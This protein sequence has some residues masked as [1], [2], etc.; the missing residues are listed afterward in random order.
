[1]QSHFDVKHAEAVVDQNGWFWSHST[2]TYLYMLAKVQML[3]IVRCSQVGLLS[4]NVF[5]QLFVMKFWFR[6][7]KTTRIRNCAVRLISP[8]PAKLPAVSDMMVL[9]TVLLTLISCISITWFMQVTSMTSMDVFLWQWMTN[10]FYIWAILYLELSP[11]IHKYVFFCV[12]SPFIH[13]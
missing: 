9:L 6:N 1:M 3:H 4:Y 7:L 12:F 13:T 11:H 10:G 5:K 8:T 2:K